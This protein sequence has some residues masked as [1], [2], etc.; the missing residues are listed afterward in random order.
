MTALAQALDDE[1]P[2]RGLAAGAGYQEK[3][4][5][6]RQDRLCGPDSSPQLLLRPARPALAVVAAA[7]QDAV[8]DDRHPGGLGAAG[9]PAIESVVVGLPVA[10]EDRVV[11]E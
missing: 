1:V 5:H 11:G 2:V 4:R 7:A 6:A 10:L 8:D 9:R 3:R